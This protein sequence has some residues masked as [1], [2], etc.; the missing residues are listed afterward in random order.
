MI[1]GPPPLSVVIF[2]VDGTLADTERDGH[3][4][5]FNDAF[6][7]HGIDMMW[8]PEQYGRLLQ[9]TG[10]RRRIAAELHRVG[11]VE[12]EDLAAE[13]HD[14]KTALF[15]ERILAGEVLPRTG[16]RDFIASLAGTGIRIAVATTGR[17]AWVDPLVGQ[18]I[19]HAVADAVLTGDDVDRLKPDPE[20]YLKTLDRLGVSPEQALAVEDSSIGL[21]AAAAAGIATVVITND[22]TRGQD[23]T[24]AAAVR[25]EYG[26][27][28][29]LTAATCQL[30]HQRWWSR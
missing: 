25:T 26:G 27:P 21:R 13:I 20:V 15:R 24:A 12:A 10:G 28:E 5:A 6:A 16:L 17:R 9:T 29:P 22:Y 30:I 18:L 19:G 23:F 3:R 11:Y 8:D 7:V 1:C 14:T 4:P 2:D